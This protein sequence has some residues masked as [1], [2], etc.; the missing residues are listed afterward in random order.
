[1]ADEFS[2][3]PALTEN[4]WQDFSFEQKAN[5]TQ[6]VIAL[7]SVEDLKDKKHPGLKASRRD[8]EKVMEKARENLLEQI[9]DDPSKL[10]RANDYLQ[11]ELGLDARP[12]SV[13]DDE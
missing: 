13:S 5:L 8:F 3:H 11:T 6:L 10:K 12:L 4:P 7:G 1:M 9:G 2:E